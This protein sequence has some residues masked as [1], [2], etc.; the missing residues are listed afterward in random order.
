MKA[1]ICAGA[2][3][4]LVGAADGALADP[5][6]EAVAFGGREYIQDMSLSPDGTKVAMIQPVGARGSAVAIADLMTSGA[7]K[8]I[9]TASGDP[10]RLTGCRWS[11]SSRLVCRLYIVRSDSGLRLAFT[12]MVAIN[13]DGS[14]LKMLTERTNSR[15]LGVAQNGGTVIDWTGGKEGSASVL[16][17]RVH[18]PEET[19]GTNLGKSKTG[20]GVDRLDTVTLA[21]SVVEQPRKGA[22]E[23]ISDGLGDVRVMGT[24]G[25]TSSGY[26]GSEVSYFYRK[27]TD[28]GWS[29]L[30]TLSLTGVGSRG[31]NPYAVDSKSNQVYGFD[32]SNGRSALWRIAL[33]GT[34]K[35]EMVVSRPDVDV[36]G[37]IQIG[38]QNRVVGASW[39]T[40]RREATF[41]D[42]ELKALSASLGR[43]L[44]LKPLVRF[45]D[46][47][48]DEK[49]LLMFAG[50]DNDAGR[51]YVF[52]K[53]TRKLEE[54][55]PVRPHADR[56]KLATMKPVS[57]PAADGTMI[58]GYLTVPAGGNGKGLPAIV[59]PHGGPGA[60]DEW[61]FD[62]LAQYFAAKGFAVLQPNFRGSSGYGEAWFQKNGFQSWRTAIGDVNDGGRWLL[63]QGIAA[64]GKLGIVGWSYGGYA[65]LQ[66]SVLDP[67]LFKGIVAIAPV[68]DL[69]TLRNDSRNYSN[70]V[71]V[72]R[73]IGS[74]AHVK[75]GSPARNVD[76]IKAPV[77]LFHGDLDLNVAVGQSR[78]MADRLKDAG[79]KVEYV[80][81]RGLDHQLDDS[82]ARIAMLDKADAF[83]KAALK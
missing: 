67:D 69:D 68:T 46:A 56:L 9:M 58:P 13:T 76:R 48:A 31:F 6:V 29:P 50:S 49:R 74:G 15:A 70:F 75:E 54:V 71:N 44:P 41:F 79:R 72:D 52:D 82:N 53:G 73:F 47:S 83:L 55:L 10:E 78:L 66:S 17:T 57:F 19:I 59:M 33:D 14:G 21:R 37:L 60:R 16:M 42:P 32:D 4:W 39:A 43:A 5:S 51:Y 34:L 36:D 27:P 12:R 62:W 28:R 30:G 45:V 61:G 11:T 63:S 8:V 80:E 40:E 65:A 25:T 64:P 77:L 20:L 38:R 81:Y 35:R 23:Y 22:V 2:A 18:V 1:F 7:P 24:I 3:L 26:S